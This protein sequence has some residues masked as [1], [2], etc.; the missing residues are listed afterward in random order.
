V[1]HIFTK[2]VVFQFNCTNTLND[3]LLL[4]VNVEM[5][6]SSAG[7]GLVEESVILCNSLPYDVPGV[8]YVAFRKEE[9]FPTGTFPA[10]LKFKVKDVDLSTGQPDEEAYDDQYELEDIELT[11]GDYAQKNL[12]ESFTEFYESLS[13]VNEVVETFN[14]SAMKT[15][16]QAVSNI[17]PILGLT[18]QERTDTVPAGKASHT[19]LLSGTLVGDIPVFIKVRLVLDAGQGVTMEI[20]VRSTNKD[21]SAIFASAIA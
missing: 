19:L 6:V 3:Q 14:L 20:A 1:K 16:Q 17:L 8:V 2:H 7:D 9:V 13:E 11:L 10:I 15:I 12:V 4:N 21:I 5:D 18:P